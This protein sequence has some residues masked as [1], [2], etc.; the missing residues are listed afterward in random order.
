MHA[1]TLKLAH[2]HKVNSKGEQVGRGTQVT[3]YKQSTVSDEFQ[4][5][6][7]NNKG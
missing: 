7:K 2:M 3:I 1:Y 4:E 6:K 5:L